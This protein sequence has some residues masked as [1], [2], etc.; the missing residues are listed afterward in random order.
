MADVVLFPDTLSDVRYWLRRHPLLV[1]FH[2]G[3]VVLRI[4]QETVIAPLVW[5]LIRISKVG[6]SIVGS[7]GVPLE[8]VRIQM[9]CWGRPASTTAANGY[10]P[11]RQMVLA[12]KS[13]LWQ[14]PS[15]T[16]INPTGQTV[17]TDASVVLDMDSPDPDTGQPRYV[18]DG[19]FAVIS[20][21]TH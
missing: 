18:V 12:L 21:I 15:G 13:A 1:P 2:A 11:L 8:T 14:L 19:Q 16:L 20:T 5:P 9:D 7:G 3:R 4:P 10:G 17:V 6:G